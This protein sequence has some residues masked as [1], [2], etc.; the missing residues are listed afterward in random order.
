M[1]DDEEFIE[2]EFTEEVTQ[3]LK[4][5]LSIEHTGQIK[6]NGLFEEVASALDLTEGALER[7]IVELLAR[8]NATP[9][10]LT[11]AQLWSLR[12]DLFEL[13]DTVLPQATC[14]RSRARLEIL[15]LQIAPMEREASD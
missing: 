2:E 14:D 4:Y 7:L 11:P 3:P 5:A 13:I 10:T 9:S 15:M 1:A 8:A 6:C 12:S